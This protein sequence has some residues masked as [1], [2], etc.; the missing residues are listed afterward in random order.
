MFNFQ[1]PEHHAAKTFGKIWNEHCDVDI[2]LI[3]FLKS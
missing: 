2:V 1:L 3:K